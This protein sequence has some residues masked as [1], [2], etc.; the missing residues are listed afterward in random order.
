EAV[1]PSRGRMSTRSCWLVA[2]Q[3][4]IGFSSS[5]NSRARSGRLS[6]SA[7]T[8]AVNASETV[9]A[10]FNFFFQA[11]DGIRD[12]TV[13]GVQTCALPISAV[14][15]ISGGP[16]MSSKTAPEPEV[17]P[18]I[19]A[20]ARQLLTLMAEK[21]GRSPTAVLESAIREKAER[22]RV[23]LPGQAAQNGAEAVP[24]ASNAVSGRIRRT[25]RSGDRRGAREPCGRSLMR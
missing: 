24:T 1:G 19:G 7:C 6:R 15:L 21:S 14:I 11:E 3:L 23:T 10:N 18:A 2:S 8:L 25:N 20:E 5:L 17:S 9:A 13:T 12:R 22:E 4:A 16:P